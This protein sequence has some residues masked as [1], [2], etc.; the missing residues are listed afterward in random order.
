MIRVSKVPKLKFDSQ[1]VMKNLA[2]VAKAGRNFIQKR[3]S[4]GIDVNHNAFTPYSKAYKETKIVLPIA[5]DR[6]LAV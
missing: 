5:A 3:T 2:S 4:R 6:Q 1:A